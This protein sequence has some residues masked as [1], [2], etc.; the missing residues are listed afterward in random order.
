KKERVVDVAATYNGITVTTTVTVRPPD[1]AM[2]AVPPSAIQCAS[3]ALVPCLT[4]TATAPITTFATTDY[5]RRYSFYTL[6]LNLLAETE[7]TSL[8][9][10]RIEYEYIWFAGQ[11]LAQVHRTTGEVAWYFNDH[12]GTPRLQTDSSAT[13]VWRAEYEPYGA[14]SAFRAGDDKYQ[15]LRLPGQEAGD[16]ELAYNIHRWYRGGWGRYSQAD[17][18][19]LEGGINLFLYTAANPLAL[20]DPL[21][22]DTAGCDSIPDANPCVKEC[23]AAHDKCFDD[24]NCTSGSWGDKPKCGCDQT[25]QCKQCN[26]SVKSCI[27]LCSL[28]AGIGS[29]KKPNYYCA[30]LHQYISI[31]K[32]FPSVEAAEIACEYDHAKD[33]KIPLSPTSPTK[34]P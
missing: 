22:L 17:P 23:C 21:G 14:V 12:L 31:P 34:K 5:A 24:N 28:K 2:Q 11:P 29:S 19:G 18:I 27:K 30:K 33:C 15:P 20:T 13:I 8:P 4:A 7:E 9:A 1:G 10:P 26:T 32:D 16:S 6:E 25:K 3:A